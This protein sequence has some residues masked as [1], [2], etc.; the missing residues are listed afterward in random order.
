MFSEVDSSEQEDVKKAPKKRHKIAAKGKGKKK[1]KKG[2]GKKRAK[3]KRFA[4]KRA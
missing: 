2:G 3:G 1:A 4:A